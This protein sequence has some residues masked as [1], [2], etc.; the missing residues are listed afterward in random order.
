MEWCIARARV[1]AEGL[2]LDPYM[3]SGSTGVAAVRMGHPFTG[4]EID[5]GYFAEACKRIAAEI[6][7]PRLRLPEPAP[8]PVQEAML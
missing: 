4:I 1:P 2:I 6:A 7:R 8:A 5:P 3:G